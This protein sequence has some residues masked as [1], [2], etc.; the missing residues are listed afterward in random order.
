MDRRLTFITFYSYRIGGILAF[1]CGSVNEKH[2]PKERKKPA[3]TSI[4]AGFLVPSFLL[5]STYRLRLE[6][7]FLP[8]VALTP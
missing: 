2:V 1:L 7:T 8:V 4:M 3:I 6:L 5:I